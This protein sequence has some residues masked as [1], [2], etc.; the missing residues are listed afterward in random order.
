MLICFD[1][2]G[3]NGDAEQHYRT[4]L[5][6]EAGVETSRDLDNEG[7]D[8]VM[9]RFRTLGFE[10]SATP[11]AYGHRAAMAT[12]AQVEGDVPA[13]IAPPSPANGPVDG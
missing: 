9:E 12:P 5:L 6:H 8:A 13:G 4:V 2:G 11:P 10:P 7:F 3:S 1:S